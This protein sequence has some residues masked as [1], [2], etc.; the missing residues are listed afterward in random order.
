MRYVLVECNPDKLLVKK[1]GIPKKSIIHAGSKSEV[2][3]RLEKRMTNSVGLIDED[4]FSVQPRYI[5]KLEILENSQKFGIRV[6]FDKTRS[7]YIIVLS[8]RLEEWIIKA[9][10]EAKIDLE[11]YNLPGD[12][13]KLHKVINSNLTKFESLL[14]ELIDK[15]DRLLALRDYLLGGVR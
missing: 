6:L 15:S 3:K 5:K 10:G 12:G 13:N 9:S 4:P 1:L 14:G 11:K 8:P 2:C 7:N